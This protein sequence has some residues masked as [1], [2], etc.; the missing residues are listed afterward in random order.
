MKESKKEKA[1]RPIGVDQ[2]QIA[3]TA[4]NLKNYNTTLTKNE[5]DINTF[6]TTT[7]KTLLTSNLKPMKFIISSFIS[8]GLHILAG[9]P[10]VGKSW[11]ALD[12]CLKIS[13]GQDMWGFSVTK[14]TSLYLC[15]EDSDLRI[16]NR[17]FNVIEFCDDFDESDYEDVHFSNESKLIGRGLEEDIKNFV[18]KYPDTTLI[19]ID[20][21]QKIRNTSNENP[22]AHDY[23]ELGSLKKIADELEIAIILVHHLSKQNYG[24]NPLARVSGTM[25]LTGTADSIFILCKDNDSN[26]KLICTGRDIEDRELKLSFNKESYK[27]VLV[28]DS[29]DEPEKFLEDD[30][31]LVY[32]FILDENFFEGTVS[33]LIE[34]LD[35]KEI[36]PNILSK[37]LFRNK[38]KL[39]E[40]GVE[41]KQ[42]KSNGRRLIILSIREEKSK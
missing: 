8:Q 16:Q 7:G 14:G 12:L 4:T 25:A 32:D 19:V 24:N 9:E 2:Q 3:E 21:L 38:I 33:E 42:R 34:N 39:Y 17:L 29:V 41:F 37:K 36:S 1:V 13:T 15:L 27:W 6:M 22:Y 28:S 35:E 31:A 26:A 20:T 40:L 18:K 30:V 23:K 11:L 5:K 10:K